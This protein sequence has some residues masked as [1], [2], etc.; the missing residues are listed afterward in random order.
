MW[1]QGFD[2]GPSHRT[3]QQFGDVPFQDLVSRNADGVVYIPLIERLVDFGFRK[4]GVGPKSNF[5]A[6]FL[7]ALDFRQQQFF[8]VVGAMRT[9]PGRSFA[10]R[11]SP[12][13]LNSSSR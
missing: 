1:D 9:L 3:R 6:E 10:A 4:G 5:L 7:L 8:P 13:R 2:T 12:S 11:Q